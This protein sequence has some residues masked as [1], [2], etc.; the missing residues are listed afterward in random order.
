MNNHEKFMTGRS[1]LKLHRANSH[2]ISSNSIRFSRY[3]L[4]S[5]SFFFFLSSYFCFFFF[6][7]K[8]KIYILI[9]IQSCWWVSDKIFFIQP[10]RRNKTTFFWPNAH[11]DKTTWNN[12]A[13]KLQIFCAFWDSEKNSSWWPY[14]LL[15]WSNHFVILYFYVIL[16][17]IWNH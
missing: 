3:S 5:Y 10:I 14:Q 6:F 4:F 7:F 2:I 12:M 1:K 16:F 17:K 8:L 15:Y 13:S 9:H 11:I